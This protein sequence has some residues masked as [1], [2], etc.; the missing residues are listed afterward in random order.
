MGLVL[1]VSHASDFTKS[2]PGAEVYDIGKAEPT[3]IQQ[4][5]EK[6]THN[7]SNIYNLGSHDKGILNKFINY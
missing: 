2:H 6:Q 4:R 7:Y 1:I 5:E 3:A